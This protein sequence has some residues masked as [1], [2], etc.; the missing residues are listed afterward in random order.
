M[1]NIPI[2]TDFVSLLA[3]RTTASGAEVLLLKRISYPANTWCQVAGRIEAEETAWQAALRELREE[4]GL[5]P[6]TLYSGDICEQFYEP[7]Q[8]AL[9]IAPVFVAVIDPEAQVVLNHEHSACCWASFDAAREMVSFGG[10]RR[11]LQAVEEEFVKRPPS[12]HLRIEV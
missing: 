11:V 8:D 12:S 10:Q 3:I 5:V 7:K 9:M 1:P 6:R 2:F 4:T